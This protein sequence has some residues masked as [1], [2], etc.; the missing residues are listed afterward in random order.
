MSLRNHT[1]T[2]VIKGILGANMTSETRLCFLSGAAIAYVSMVAHQPLLLRYFVP[3][4]LKRVDRS[5]D[6][7]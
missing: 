3:I 7:R 2:I 5:D 6:G 4:M 1:S